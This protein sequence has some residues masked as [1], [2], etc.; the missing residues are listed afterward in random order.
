MPPDSK[1][2]VYAAGNGQRFRIFATCLPTGETIP[3]TT[4]HGN[5]VDPDVCRAISFPERADR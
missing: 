2:V 5:D 3:L 1:Q 4:N